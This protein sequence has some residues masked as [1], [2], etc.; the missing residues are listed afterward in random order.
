MHREPWRSAACRVVLVLLW[1]LA[2][3]AAAGGQSGTLTT[4]LVPTPNCTPS[5]TLA[6][7]GVIYFAESHGNKL[8]RLD[9]TTNIVTEWDVGQG[10]ERLAL[11]SAGAIYFTERWADRIGRILPAGNYYTSEGFGDAGSEPVGLVS[12]IAGATTLWYT[13]KGVSKIARLSLGGLMFDVLQ[14]RIPSTHV[15]TPTTAILTPSTALVAPRLTPGNPALPP[16]IALAPQASSGPFSEW[17]LP[18]GAMQLRDLVLSAG[19][20]VFVSTETNSLLE[21]DP[22]SSTVLFH[23]LP[24]DSMSLRL[25]LDAAGRVWFTESGNEKIGRL[26]PTNGDVTEW[27]VIGSH[28]SAIVVTPDG[29]VWYTD[30]ERD[31]IAHLDPT[32]GML[33]EYALG[34]NADPLDLV[35]D[36]AGSLW[37][38]T[39]ENWIGR[40]T[41]GPVLGPPPVADAIVDIHAVAVSSTQARVT[42]DYVYS[43]SHGLPIYVGGLPTVGGAGV[44]SVGYVPAAIDA[45]GA[46]SVSFDLMFVGSGCLATEGLAVYLYDSSRATFVS[47]ETP[48]ALTWGSCAPSSSVLPGIS[49][50]VD[51]GCGGAYAIGDAVVISVTATESVTATLLDFETGGTQ[52][53]IGLGTIPSGST[54]T[55][56]GTV[57]G[58]AGVEGLLVMAKTASETWVSAGCTLGVAGAS[59]SA[60]SVSVDR[61]C[62]ATY[63]YGETASAVLQSSVIGLARLYQ[64]TRDGHISLVGAYPIFPGVTE[65]VAA[66]VSHTTGVSTF[67]LQV[68]SALGEVLAAT[69]SYRVVP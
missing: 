31:K 18:G 14:G 62:N 3:S 55:V 63:H 6:A 56:T 23:D 69:C 47:S 44:G 40:L 25:A 41:V 60:V 39:E 67:L 61:G 26:D 7:D 46:G 53:Q 48:V 54:R 59:S 11:G 30:R 27:A 13:E 34:A 12:E 19:G 20:S 1:L 35:L 68:T 36:S 5:G 38:T 65:R 4:W 50:H 24:S 28:P 17:T 9:P 52:K 42:V 15:V 66:P 58:P 2:M 49:V 43:G 57:S 64:V 32:T 8:A 51:R 16:G 21:L 10:P 45:A 33:S 37:F 22:T 29:T